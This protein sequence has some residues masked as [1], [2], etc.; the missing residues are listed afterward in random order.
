MPLTEKKF[1]DLGKSNQ[2]STQLENNNIAFYAAW[3]DEE[4]NNEQQVDQLID[5]LGCKM[6]GALTR[7]IADYGR[8]KTGRTMPV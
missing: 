1:R 8:A 2:T 5:G 6:I 7:D 4:M 3:Q